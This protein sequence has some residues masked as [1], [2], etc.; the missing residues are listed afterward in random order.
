VLTD[1]LCASVP[2]LCACPYT[3]C[4]N[5]P[6]VELRQV[7]QYD[8]PAQE[9]DLFHPEALL[10]RHTWPPPKNPLFFTE[11]DSVAARKKKAR[12]GPA[13]WHTD[14]SDAICRSRLLPE[15]KLAIDSKVRRVAQEVIEGQGGSLSFTDTS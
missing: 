7:R 15:H 4:R 2:I 1:V 6:P 8:Q 12:Q 10:L 13:F 9:L 5:G 11:D 3:P 14:S